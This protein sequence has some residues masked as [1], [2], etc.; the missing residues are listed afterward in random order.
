APPTVG[1]LRRKLPDAGWHSLSLTL[2]DPQGA[3]L[4]VRVA[5]PPASTDGKA[6]EPAA[7]KAPEPSTPA[8][9]TE[10]PSPDAE[11]ARA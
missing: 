1:P 5:T 10:A 9:T 7:E 11:A 2:P 3:S 6:A 4:P 8:P